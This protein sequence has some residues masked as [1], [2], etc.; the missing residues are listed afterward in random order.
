MSPLGPTLETERLVLRPPMAE[1]LPAWTAFHAD[2]EVMK[3]LG[4]VQA[5]ST[6]WRGL[7]G[8]A[9]AWAL[10][11]FGMFSVLERT[12]GRWI[13]R[14]GPW[15]PPGWPGTEVGWGL[16]REAWGQGYALEAATATIDWAIDTLGWTD[17]IHCVD[18]AN[19]ASARLAARLG[20]TNRGPGSLPAPFENASVDLWGQGADEWRRH[21]G[22]PR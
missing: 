13:G 18:P 9:G 6:A 20:A 10:H 4:G 3:F 19:V 5:E 1:D 7:C 21:T 12:T 8:M 15:Q 14:V 2:P 22:A 11:A 17:I 16:A